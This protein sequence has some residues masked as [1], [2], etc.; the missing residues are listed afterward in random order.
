[1]VDN[2]MYIIRL[3]LV[4]DGYCYGTI[5]KNCQEGNSPVRAVPSADG[6]LVSRLNAAFGQQDV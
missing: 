1:M 4:Q 6:Y 5:G 2:V 3:E